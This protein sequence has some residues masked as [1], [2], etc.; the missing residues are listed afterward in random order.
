MPSSWYLVT[1]PRWVQQALHRRSITCRIAATSLLLEYTLGTAAVARAVTSYSGALLAGD[2]AALRLPL[3]SGAEG[4]RAVLQLDLPALAAIVALAGVLAAG[5]RGSAALNTAVNIANLLVILFVLATG[6]PYFQLTNFV[7]LMPMGMRG[8]VAGASKVS[9][10]HGAFLWLHTCSQGAL[11]RM[12]SPPHMH[13]YACRACMRGRGGEPTLGCRRCWRTG[14][15]SVVMHHARRTPHVWGRSHRCIGTRVVLPVSHTAFRGSDNAMRIQTRPG[16]S[17]VSHPRHLLRCRLWQRASGR[18]RG[19][20]VSGR[21][22]Q[23]SCMLARAD[24]LSERVHSTVE[25]G[26]F[27]ALRRA[28]PHT[29]DPYA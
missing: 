29:H 8:A 15:T 4:G 18:C 25:C 9:C 2:A 23:L 19:E 22:R 12:C 26:Q 24:Q 21:P 28:A 20:N 3:S 16:S 10:I 27:P 5:T 1:H 7:P 11:L 14:S 17:S 13:V 6:L